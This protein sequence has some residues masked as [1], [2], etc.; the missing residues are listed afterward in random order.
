MF[1]E[2]IF[3][4]KY[5]Y[6]Y[7]TKIYDTFFKISHIVFFRHSTS[8]SPFCY[9]EESKKETERI[10]SKPKITFRSDQVTFLNL[11]RDKLT[12][13]YYQKTSIRPKMEVS[14]M[15]N[16]PP[17]P[18][19][20]SESTGDN[21][22]DTEEKLCAICSDRST[23]RH[24][25]VYSCEGCKNFFRRS[26]RKDVKY[27]CPAYGKCPVHKDQRTRCKACRLKKCLK[28]GMRKEGRLVLFTNLISH[29]FFFFLLFFLNHLGFELDSYF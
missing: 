19:L 11:D 1:W 18:D 22:T 29:L 24:Y 26:V 20:L 21:K 6:K 3:T 12:N 15:T 25:K 27:V 28:A 4:R 23:G 5:C 17:P 16:L 10:S 9:Y 13:Q 2:R 8:L 7:I 14:A